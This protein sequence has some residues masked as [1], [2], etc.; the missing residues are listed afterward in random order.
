MGILEIGGNGTQMFGR[1]LSNTVNL[2]KLNKGAMT[3]SLQGKGNQ[4]MKSISKVLKKSSINTVEVPPENV[5]EIKRP[6]GLGDKQRVFTQLIGLLITEAYR[7]GYELTFGDAYRDD[8]CPYG[9]Q[10]SLHRKR[11]AIDLNLFKNGVWLTKTEDHTELGVFWEN[12]HP[13][14]KWG[15]RFQKADG[16]HYSYQHQGMK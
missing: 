15:G 16:N 5:I 9:H 10:N 3:H 14:C 1:W 13:D 12:L 2:F 11:L 6:T 7:L 4:I 8:R